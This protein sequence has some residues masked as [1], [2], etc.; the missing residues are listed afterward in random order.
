MYEQCVGNGPF[1]STRHARLARSWAAHFGRWGVVGMWAGLRRGRG[2]CLGLQ[3][4]VVVGIF[5]FIH[6]FIKIFKK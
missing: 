1:S 4:V 3:L 5:L 2:V 6:F